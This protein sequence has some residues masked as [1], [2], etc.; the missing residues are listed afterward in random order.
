MT[1]KDRLS[2]ILV[3]QELGGIHPILPRSNVSKNDVEYLLS[4]I[5]Q[6]TKALESARSCFSCIRHNCKLD[7][8]I[9]ALDISSQVV[10]KHIDC[11][12]DIVRKALSDNDEG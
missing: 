6:L 4:R 8:F 3:Q 9:L 10:L 5:T 2:D 1:H 12:E 11:S 7:T